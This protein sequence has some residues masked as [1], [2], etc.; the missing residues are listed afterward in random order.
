MNRTGRVIVIMLILIGCAGGLLWFGKGKIKKAQ[1]RQV[2]TM[3]EN[4]YI[5]SVSGSVITVL[6]EGNNKEYTA[7]SGFQEDVTGCRLDIYRWSA[8]QDQ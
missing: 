8:Y 1:P 2:I 4:I 5:T 6:E 3:K 7:S